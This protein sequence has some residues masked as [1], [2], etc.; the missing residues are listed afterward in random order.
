[1]AVAVQAHPQHVDID[2]VDID[3]VDSA[4][5]QDTRN[6][7]TD[8]MIYAYEK[9]YIMQNVQP[10]INPHIQLPPLPNNLIRGRVMNPEHKRVALRIKQQADVLR[11]TVQPEIRNAVDGMRI[12]WGAPVRDLYGSFRDV[13]ETLLKDTIDVSGLT[14]LF[15]FTY[16]FGKKVL[17]HAFGENIFQIVEFTTK[18]IHKEKVVKV[19]NKAA[20]TIADWVVSQGGWS[21]VFLEAGGAVGLG[22]MLSIHWKTVGIFAVGNL[23]LW[24]LIKTLNV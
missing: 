4:I 12:D 5:Y 11:L 16:E 2:E 24:R 8:F 14:V 22:A 9:D 19:A 7:T 10:E 21:N 15:L 1:M 13:V 20:V 17:R 6:I 3:E 23:L 18:F